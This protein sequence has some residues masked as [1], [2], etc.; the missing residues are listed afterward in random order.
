MARVTREVKGLREL[1]RAL[2]ELPK[3]VRR[4]VLLGALRETAK[5]ILKDAR[6]R[7]PKDSGVTAKDL[8]IRAVPKSETDVGQVAVAIAGSESKGGRSYIMR[9]LEFGT[10]KM[11]AKPFFRPAVDANAEASIPRFAKAAWERT[12]REVRKLAR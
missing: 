10:E 12:K 9:F 11:A 8:K 5:P 3:R 7:M 2:A 6:Q 1:D 4:R